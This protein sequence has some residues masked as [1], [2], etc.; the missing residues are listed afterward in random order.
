MISNTCLFLFSCKHIIL[1]LIAAKN[2]VQG[3]CIH[4]SEIK[5]DIKQ[6]C[7][8]DLPKTNYI[9]CLT[10][11]ETSEPAADVR[12]TSRGETALGGYMSTERLV[13]ACSSHLRNR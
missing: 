6:R 9:L 12:R 7:L 8:L 5:Y 2:V 11:I 1:G 4:Y 10:T 3:A 13:I